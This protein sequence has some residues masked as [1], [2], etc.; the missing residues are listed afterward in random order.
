MLWRYLKIAGIALAAFAATFVLVVGLML[1]GFFSQPTARMAF[2]IAGST[3]GYTIS[4]EEFEGNIFGAFVCRNLSVGDEQGPFFAASQL[5]FSW[6]FFAAVMGDLNVDYLRLAGGALTRE[7]E[8]EDTGEPPSLPDWPGLGIRVDELLLQQ[9]RIA[10][11]DAPEICLNG[12]ARAE[13]AEPILDLEARFARCGAE[14]AVVATAQIDAER[15]QLNVET[16]DDGDL[17]SLLLGW[18]GAGDTEIQIT[19]SGPLTGFAGHLDAVVIGGGNAFLD[20]VALPGN[21]NI[22]GGIGINGQIA[23][24]EGRAP[25]WAPATEGA[26]AAQ[27]YFDEQGGI[28]ID[29]GAVEW[30]NANLNV[31]LTRSGEG[32]LNGQLSAMLGAYN[33][34]VA[35][36]SASLNLNVTGDED[37]Q[38]ANGD[39]AVNAFCADDICADSIGGDVAATFDGDTLALQTQGNT[40]ALRVAEELDEIFGDNVAYNLTGNYLLADQAAAIEGTLQGAQ[41]G[42]MLNAQL[43]LEDGTRGSGMV[44]IALDQNATIGGTTLPEAVSLDVN[45]EEFVAGGAISG[46][47]ELASNIMDATGAIALAED[48]TID[49]RFETT[50]ASAELLSELTGVAFAEPPSLSATVTGTTDAPVISAQA[51]IPGV[52]SGD[53]VLT[54]AAW[55]LDVSRAEG[56]WSGQST[57]DAESSAG[58]IVLAANVMQAEGAPVRIVIA[59]SRIADADVSAELVIPEDDAPPTGTA[60]I[61]GNALAPLGILLGEAASSTGAIMA[62]LENE[63][64]MQS[65]A[66]EIDLSNV[67]L[68]DQLDG[69]TVEGTLDYA[70]DAQAAEAELSI[71]QDEDR[72]TVVADAALGDETVVN[73]RTLDGVWAETPIRLLRPA[74][75]RTGMGSTTLTGAEIAFGEGRIEI[76]ASQNETGLDA[77]IALNA[78]PIEPILA[79]QGNP[80]AQGAINGAFS[81]R[82]TPLESQGRVELTLDDFAFAN[83]ERDVIPAD[84]SLQGDWDGRAFTLAG[85]ITGL[86]ENP[87]QFNASLPLTRTGEGYSVAVADDAPLSGSFTGTARAERFIGLL[88]IAEHNFTGPITVSL[89]LEGT[90]ANPVYSGQARLQDGTYESL[91]F[92]TRFEALN[93]TISASAD[94]AFTVEVDATDGDSGR[95]TVNGN[96][97]F[98]EDARP[99]GTANVEITNAYLLRRDELIARG[100]GQVNVDFPEEG[101][102]SIEGNF[103]TA[104]VR[105][106]LGQPLPASVTEIDVVEINRPA[107]LG[108]IEEEPV[109]EGPDFIG[110]T[111]LDFEIVMPN[112][113]RVEGYGVDAEWQGNIDIGGTVADPQIDG[114]IEL[115]RGFA[116]LLGRQF[117]L[118]EGSIVPDADT[119]GG[120][121]VDMAASYETN[122]L[123]VN[124]DISGPAA[125][126]DI[127]WSS[128]PELPRDEI[129]SRVYFG[130]ASPQLSAY[131]ALQL[132]QL[133]GALGGAGAGGIT[134]FARNLAGLDVLRIEAPANGDISNPTITVGKY[135][136][137]RVYV[138][139]RR[140]ADT[141]SSAIEVEVDITPH[142]SAEV[143]TGTDNS[144]AAAVNWQWDY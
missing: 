20:I 104:E 112:N 27:I 138:G 93:A 85:M 132:A 60:L 54:D 83:I 26:V 5:E 44:R 22:R 115:I 89:Q 72:V 119:A 122:D 23:L 37:T 67:T 21:G 82:M 25:D 142:I 71:V 35:F 141:S 106:D 7:P 105:I 9:F 98:G 17:M 48:Q 63:G 11:P 77:Q 125:M 15:M 131:E 134:G 1:A 13:I 73:L 109:E 42:A 114:E 51:S 76:S 40:A 86:D 41:G 139:A 50:R 111:T 33:G 140:D 61:E 70:L 108:A 66:L 6:H 30:G 3:T 84:F 120:A 31:A 28:R 74:V 34:A 129:I 143:E 128:V 4:C 56:T 8:S 116:E 49:V 87:A 97:S 101:T 118:D 65:I 135:V 99:I 88:P 16:M 18:D 46:T 80:D 124:I 136:T 96:L 62:T 19:G 123:T 144:Q 64:G 14:G 69:A 32:M 43:A 29:N 117:T 94:R 92:G 137:E 53:F 103:R 45:V 107:E 24:A 90:A 39:Y 10:L 47:V 79:A 110:M 58:A 100:S 12:A 113:V 52:T 102:P 57:L 75:L 36:Q 121:R 55:D 127:E 68:G 59:D 133:S 91:E 95:L 126:P 38:T 78:L 2:D 81:A 130:R